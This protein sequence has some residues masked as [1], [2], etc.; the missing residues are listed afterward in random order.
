MTTE[1]TRR[2]VL[3]RAVLIATLALPPAVHAAEWNH[4]NLQ[5]LVDVRFVSTDVERS[6]TQGGIGLGR[7]DESHDGPELGRLSFDYRASLAETL[8]AH[9]TAGTYADRDKNPLDLTEAFLEWRPY[10]SS[11]WRWRTRL[12]AFYPPI[13]LENRDSGWQSPYSLSPGAIN[14]WLGEELRTIG[15]ETSL[16]WLGSQSGKGVDV[17]LVGA[18]YEWNDPLGV[19]IFERGWAIHDRQTALFGGLPK[20]FPDSTTR[21]Q[22]EFFHEI[23]NR[24]GYYV[25]VQAN[26]P[27]RFV[28]RALH[29][30]NRGDPGASNGFENAWLTRFD[31]AGVRYEW[32]PDWTF[33]AQWMDGDT[34]VGASTDGLGFLRTAFESYFGLVSGAF[35]HH[36]FTVR[37]DR[38]TTYTLRGEEYF[39]G[40]QDAKGWTVGYG[41]DFG[42]NW[43]LW[44][45]ALQ[46]KGEL[47]QRE[48][49]GLD[50]VF[51]ERTLQCAFR[52]RY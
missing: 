13:S 3:H 31:S 51:R 8:D 16:T 44:L 48:L 26:W 2:R 29:Y 5:V 23:D 4:Q 46:V 27:E 28:V 38:L 39:D 35:G 50:S 47:E 20:I 33:I 11:A 37:Y 18:I 42:S 15:A 36:R 17:G 32:Q 30:D 6:F 7:F 52:F 9:V 12:G 49:L 22:V 24:P 40:Y 19:Q 1:T 14:T 45:E 21:H 25:G 10:P 41:F 43:E 34:A